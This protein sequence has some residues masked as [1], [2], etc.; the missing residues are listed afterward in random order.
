MNKPGLQN[1]SS[2]NADDCMDNQELHQRETMN[3]PLF[4]LRMNRKTQK[5]SKNRLVDRTQKRG[6][7]SIAPFP[8]EGT[9]RSILRC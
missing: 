9:V 6:D 3:F 2:E 4:D 1:Q 5:A 8:K 7:S